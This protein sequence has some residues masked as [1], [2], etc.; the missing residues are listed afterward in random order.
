M[1][2]FV[3]MYDKKN[4]KSPEVHGLVEVEKTDAFPF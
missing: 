2:W 3:Y 1:G 4:K